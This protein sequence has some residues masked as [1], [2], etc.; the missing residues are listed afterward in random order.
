MTKFNPSEMEQ[1]LL[2]KY[3]L[4][5]LMPWDSVSTWKNK[6]GKRIERKD[7]KRPTDSA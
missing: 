2:H 1:Y 5:P 4:I 3:Q 6:D 7:G